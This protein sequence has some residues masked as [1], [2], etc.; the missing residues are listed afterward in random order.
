MGYIFQKARRRQ[1][2]FFEVY[3]KRLSVTFKLVGRPARSRGGGGGLCLRAGEVVLWFAP[4]N[5]GAAGPE[6]GPAKTLEARTGGK[7]LPSG[8]EGGRI[9]TRKTWF[10]RDPKERGSRSTRTHVS[11]SSCTGVLRDSALGVHAH[12][13][14][15]YLAVL[16]RVYALYT[17]RSH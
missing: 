14:L 10:E 6:L 3:S 17:T 12:G 4:P 9:L 7:S 15:V 16:C 8:R 5:G 2:T 11:V 1:R 13:W